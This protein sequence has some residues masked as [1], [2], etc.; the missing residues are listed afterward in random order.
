MGYNLKG[1][2]SNTYFAKKVA[3]ELYMPVMTCRAVIDAY[4]AAL[5][6]SLLTCDNS[7]ILDG[8]IVFN[9]YKRK[10]KKYTNLTPNSKK[11]GT[12]RGKGS[13]GISQPTFAIRNTYRA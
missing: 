7:V 4:T 2:R 8:S 1:R 12:I 9:R 3:K 11:G 13:S 5:R 10:A 6:D